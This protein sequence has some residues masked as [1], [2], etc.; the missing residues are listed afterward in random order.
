MLIYEYYTNLGNIDKVMFRLE[1]NQI[2]FTKNINNQ[3]YH[4][5]KNVKDD[6]TLQQTMELVKRV[7]KLEDMFWKL[8]EE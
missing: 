2:R 4:I 1:D 6:I 8:V 3:L 5:T 7:T